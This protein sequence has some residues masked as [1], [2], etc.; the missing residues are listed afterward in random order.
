MKYR[1][2]NRAK[3]FST[4]CRN[5]NACPYCRGSRTFSNYRR[6]PI[7]EDMMEPEQID[8]DEKVSATDLANVADEM[9]DSYIYGEDYGARPYQE[10]REI[11]VDMLERIEKYGID[12]DIKQVTGEPL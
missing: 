9:L 3:Q 4:Q 8:S 12:I 1:K 7:E 6:A 11:Y 2:V 5:N 10:I